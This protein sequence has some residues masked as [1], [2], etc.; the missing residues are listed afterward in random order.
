MLGLTMLGVVGMV[1]SAASASAQV[2]DGL[3][4]SSSTIYEPQPSRERIRVDATFT[5]TNRQP[6]EVIGDQVRSYY[7][8]KWVIA[9][10]AAVEDFNATSDQVAL[11]T[12]I[13]ADPGSTDIVFASIALPDDLRF[14][15]SVQIDVGYTIPGSQPR[16]EGAIARVNDSFLSFS[17]WTAGDPGMADVRVRIPP[18]FRVDLQGDL[19]ELDEVSRNGETMLEALAI[20]RPQDFFGQV[21]GR[22]DAGLITDYA[23]LPAGQAT[24]RAWPDDP[25]WAAFVVDA[26]EDDVPVLAG[27]TGL[28]WAAG[29]IEVIETVTPYLFGYGGW[30]N[31]SSGVIEVGET[32]ERDLILHELAHAWF[33]DELVEG[34]WITEGLAEEYAS[35]TIE[36][37][38]DT[39]PDPTEPDPADPIRVPLAS[40]ASPW[41]IEEEDAYAYERYH[42]NASWWVIRQITDEIGLEEFA[43]VLVALRDDSL[44]YPGERP[45]EQTLEPTRW[46]HLFDLLDPH[47][48]D[49]RL[50]ELFTT[51]VLEPAD[52]AGLQPRRDTL[53]R[54]HELVDATDTWS[55]P[56]IV[57]RD[58]ASWRFDSA[59]AGID[60]AL[61]II[62]V[63]DRIDTSAENLG[64][65]V[66]HPGELSYEDAASLDALRDVRAAEKSLLAELDD[67]TR[68]RDVLATRAAAIGVDV[69]YEPGTPD[70]AAADTA[71]LTTSL[72]RIERLRDEVD[73]RAGALALDTPTWSTTTGGD[74]DD[75]IAL[76]EA[77]LATLDAIERATSVVDEPRTL[78]EQLGL[79]R[80]DPARTLDEAR[81]AFEIDALD[82]ALVATAATEAAVA[83]AGSNG[84]TRATWAGA[85]VGVVLMMALVIGWSARRRRAQCADRPSEPVS[86]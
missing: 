18:G 33:N 31:A 50:D 32:L 19:D 5:L 59:T 61:A 68:T 58:L 43:A 54:Y 44:P 8:T 12:T 78:I 79:W 38:G 14:D 56:L 82:D 65:R 1:A 21:F 36:A 76:A 30:F 71:L 2:A 20:D 4:V 63:R 66:E 67:L 41:T 34:R 37:T 40:W 85:T 77:R 29:D 35:R 25:E 26:I 13:E 16:I 73:T 22:N 47:F 45:G 28:E 3:E 57:R 7:Y 53:A 39:R 72:D 27:L 9:L 62:D 86:R 52:A 11:R 48:D 84:T 70:E 83:R 74:I 46:T 49:D 10:P 55:P 80:R 24:V 42:Y 6:D 81:R 17:V 23:E 15:E 75:A 64:V 69:V 60:E 51:H